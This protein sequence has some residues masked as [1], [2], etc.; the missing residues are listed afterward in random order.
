MIR[1][2]R[3]KNG[4]PLYGSKCLLSPRAF[5]SENRHI[6][7]MRNRYTV[8]ICSCGLL[9]IMLI[10]AGPV[11]ATTGLSSLEGLWVL[12]LIFLGVVMV[13]ATVVAFIIYRKTRR[14]WVFFLIPVIAIAIAQFIAWILWFIQF[15]TQG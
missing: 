9:L 2:S 3:L 8:G 12:F 10:T 15:I 5:P 13:L 7:M 4:E 14:K 11:H 6:L 1:L